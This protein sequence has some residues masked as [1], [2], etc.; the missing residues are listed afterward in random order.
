M[1][2]QLAAILAST[3]LLGAAGLTAAAAD[4]VAAAEADTWD[5]SATQEW[6]EDGSGEMFTISTAEDL[7][8][9]AEL[10][11]GGTNFA[12]K[13]ITLETDIDLADI[14]WT[15]IGKAGALFSGTFDGQDHTIS[16]LKITNDQE[17]YCGFFYCLSGAAV[18]D[19]HISGADVTSSGWTGMLAGRAEDAEITG[20]TVSGVLVAEGPEPDPEAEPSGVAAAGLVEYS[21]QSQITDCSSDVTVNVSSLG[22]WFTY[23]GGIACEVNGGAIN[24]CTNTGAITGTSS[25]NEKSYTYAGGI[26]TYVKNGATVTGCTNTGTITAGDSETYY[27]T[28]G[29]ILGQIWAEAPGTITVTGCTNTGTVT[30]TASDSYKGNQIGEIY[31]Y[32]NIT[33]KKTNTLV[34]DGI[35]DDDIGWEIQD[36]IVADLVKSNGDVYGYPTLEGALTDAEPGDTVEMTRDMADIGSLSI[37]KNI[38]FEGRGHIISG[39]SSLNFKGDVGGTVQNVNFENIHNENNNKSAIYASGLTAELVVKDCSFDNVDWDCIQ[40]TPYADTA[41]VV[42]T[43]N[44]FRN[45]SIQGQ[46]F[47]H[48]ESRNA[49]SSGQYA[50]YAFS[51]EITGN[52]FYGTDGNLS[53][54]ALEVYFFTAPEKVNLE[55]NYFQDPGK[56]WLS[57]DYVTFRS[58]NDKI[59]PYYENEEMTQLVYLPTATVLSAD[60]VDAVKEGAEGTIRFITKVDALNGTA[61]SFGTYILPLFVFEH[62]EKD[63]SDELTAVVTY[64]G[65]DIAAD[66]TYAADLTGIPEKYFGEDIV[67]QSFMVVDGET[68]T[69]DLFNAV[70]VDDLAQ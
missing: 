21:Y 56:V 22:N 31:T 53:Q 16:N 42:I 26:A 7:A 8:G 59:Y 39:D 24:N 50:N 46:R 10:V 5:G 30:A 40:V 3:M 2:K 45:S 57:S 55:K 60:A 67:A 36:L 43:G 68:V 37:D 47:I 66:Q 20:C 62:V 18:T 11:N 4:P 32:N 64:T 28:A 48:V 70:S 6:Y 14:E 25:D 52:K 44:A 19:L 23:A 63:W 29:G 54:E 9:L 49:A 51:A 1:K 27:A 17:D 12:G 35:Q 34:L 38:I 69:S 13:T 65:E 61:T 58:E 33:G 41:S 15:P